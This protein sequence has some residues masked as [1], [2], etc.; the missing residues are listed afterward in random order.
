MTPANLDSVLDSGAKLV[1]VNNRNL[2]TMQVDL[3][4][5]L[6]VHQSIPDEIVFV[7]ESGIK[8]NQDAERLRCAGID[9]MLVGESLMR[10]DDI[11]QAGKILI[12]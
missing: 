11:L 4:H 6:D 1:G 3:G 7:G 12:R 8:T 9:A 5:C 10:Q 2:H